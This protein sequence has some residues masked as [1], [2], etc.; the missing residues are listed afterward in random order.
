MVAICGCIMPAP[1]ATPVTAPRPERK[2]ML[3]IFG[4]E[5]VVRIASE[6]L[7]RCPAHAPASEISTFK[8]EVILL[9]GSGTPIMPVDEGNTSAGLIFRRLAVS[10]QIFLQSRSPDVPVAQ[11]AFPEF[12]TTARTRPLLF[13]IDVRPTWTGAAVIRLRVNSAAAD[14][15][16]SAITNARSSFP[17][18]L[19][20][21]FAAENL[22]PLG[23]TTG[24]GWIILAVSPGNSRARVGSRI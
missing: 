16:D 6:N 1:F 14:V 3:A 11:F 18:A 9:T 21:A 7:R 22:N 12:T 5:S 24:P 10:A 8:C 19:M 17:L 23:I 13:A 20:L 15:F 4:F 2:G